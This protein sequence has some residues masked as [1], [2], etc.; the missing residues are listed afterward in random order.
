LLPRQQNKNVIFKKNESSSFSETRRHISLLDDKNRE[1]NVLF[2][3]R[4]FS[5]KQIVNNTAEDL[6]R[7]FFRTGRKKEKINKI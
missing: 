4:I 7:N 6:K 5:H 3:K 1:S 2:L